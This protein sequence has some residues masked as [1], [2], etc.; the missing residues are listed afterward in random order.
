MFIWTWI[1]GLRKVRNDL[2]QTLK[3]CQDVKE[4]RDLQHE[5][6]SE[7]GTDIDF[8]SVSFF[9]FFFE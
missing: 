2:L 6:V 8:N 3:E 5:Y 9:V 1:L 4:C 7:L